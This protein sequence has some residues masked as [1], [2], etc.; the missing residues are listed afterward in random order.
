MIGAAGAGLDSVPR[1]P[2]AVGRGFF[3][4]IVAAAL[5]DVD[6]AADDGLYV[7][8]AGFVEKICGGE[9]VAVIGD[10]H[11]G[12]FLAGGFVKKFGG[13]ARAVQQAEIGVNVKMNELRIAHGN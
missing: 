13:F 4:A 6:F 7:A 10:G 1:S 5:G 9:E 3:A 12:H 11:R 8:L 2:F